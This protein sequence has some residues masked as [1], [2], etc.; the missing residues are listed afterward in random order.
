MR[1][2]TFTSTFLPN[3]GEVTWP[4]SL[5]EM[6]L[7]D[8][9]IRIICAKRLGHHRQSVKYC[10]SGGVDGGDDNDDDDDDGGGGGA[11][12]SERGGSGTDLQNASEQWKF[13]SKERLGG[14]PL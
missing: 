11:A 8:K 2:H 10:S 13:S 9:I 5:C 3:L 12:E 14:K 6:T 1:K 4:F 7:L